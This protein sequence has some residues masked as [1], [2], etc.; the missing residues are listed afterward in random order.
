MVPLLP[1]YPPTVI[2]TGVKLLACIIASLDPKFNPNAF[3]KLTDPN[4]FPF[5]C[6]VPDNAIAF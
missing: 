4:K 3:G 1:R 5:S 2:V 6:V